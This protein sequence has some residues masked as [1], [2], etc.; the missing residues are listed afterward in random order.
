MRRMVDATLGDLRALKLWQ[1]YPDEAVLA[2]AARD[3]LN[4]G[5]AVGYAVGRDIG[6][7]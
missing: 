4:W 1:G 6:W 5:E 7:H 2:C 3:A